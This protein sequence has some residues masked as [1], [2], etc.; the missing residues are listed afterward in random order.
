MHV[1][2][3]SVYMV[4][5]EIPNPLVV[6]LFLMT[7]KEADEEDSSELSEVLITDQPLHRLRQHGSYGN[8]GSSGNISN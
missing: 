7:V 6:Q 3:H 4:V 2:C 5:D 1:K 8:S